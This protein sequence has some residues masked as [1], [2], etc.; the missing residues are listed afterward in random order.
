[1]GGRGMRLAPTH[2]HFT[3]TTYADSD[4]RPVLELLLKWLRTNG[5]KD[6][7]TDRDTWVTSFAAFCATVVSGNAGSLTRRRSNAWNDRSC[8]PA[9]TT[10]T[11]VLGSNGDVL[12]D[13]SPNQF[14]K[15]H[16]RHHGPS[17]SPP[18]PNHQDEE[19]WMIDE[20]DGRDDRTFARSMNWRILVS[21][22]SY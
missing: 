7:Y 17:L 13:L 14:V 16:R 10:S 1:M 2:I 20:T 22:V 18:H 19:L 9:R 8:N 21:W 12:T 15:G 5:I 6:V 11:R 4:P 3:E